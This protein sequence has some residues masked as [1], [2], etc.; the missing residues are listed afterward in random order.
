MPPTVTWRPAGKCIIKLSWLIQWAFVT[1]GQSSWSY[2]G[3]PSPG[4]NV[5]RGNLLQG[6]RIS[7]P[8]CLSWCPTPGELTWPNSWVEESEWVSVCS[9]RYVCNGIQWDSGMY[10]LQMASENTNQPAWER[11]QLKT[12]NTLPLY[13]CHYWAPTYKT[14]S[15]HYMNRA[16]RPQPRRY[17]AC[18]KLYQHSIMAQSNSVAIGVSARRLLPIGTRPYSSMA[19]GCEKALAPL[20]RPSGLNVQ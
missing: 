12:I 11:A 2:W 9:T 8:G 3:N 7:L 13:M 14:T 20:A 6:V 17:T 5:H 4:A 19:D 18:L 16:S 1:L 15:T 10:R